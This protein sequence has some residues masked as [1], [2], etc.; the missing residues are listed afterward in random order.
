MAACWRTAELLGRGGE[1]PMAT[2]PGKEEQA[3]ANPGRVVA[4][5]APGGAAPER[6]PAW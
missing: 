1:M 5:A 2:T 4:P 3:A 6:R